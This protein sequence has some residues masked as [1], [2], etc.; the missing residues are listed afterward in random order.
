MSLLQRLGGRGSAAAGRHLVATAHCIP[1]LAAPTSHGRCP[2]ARAAASEAVDQAATAPEP[3][4]RAGDVLEELLQPG[5]GLE[6][7]TFTELGMDP[8]FL[9]GCCTCM[10]NT[11]VCML[12]AFKGSMRLAGWLCSARAA[13]GVPKG[14]VPTADSSMAAGQCA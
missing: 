10:D 12:T 2:P 14:T 7:P 13:A 8:M 11:Q 9:V 1:R 3:V 6:P 4:D 5:Q